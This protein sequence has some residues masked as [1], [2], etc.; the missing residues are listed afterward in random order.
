MPSF[1]KSLLITSFILIFTGLHW[2]GAV[3]QLTQVNINMKSAD[4]SAYMNYA[5]KM[6]Q[7]NYTFIGGRNRMPIYPFL[8]SLFYRPGMSNEAFFIRGKYV[9]LILSLVL[10]TGITFI[11]S[12]F[13][14]WLHTVN[15][16]L[17]TAFT[18]FVFKAGYFQAE[19]LFYFINFCLFLLM[20]RLLQQP[21]HLLAILTGFVAGLAHLT[22]ASIIP[23]L[24]LFLLFMGIQGAWTVYQN[25][26]SATRVT[27]TKSL[28]PHFLVI[29]L[30]G[31]CF[32]I[33]VYPYI[34]TSRRVFG[35]YFYNVNST[36]YVWY[37]SW[38][39]V[40]QGTR[41]HGDRVGW[42]NMPPEEIPSM[43]KYIREHTLQHI[44]ARFQYGKQLVLYNVMNNS[45]GYFK[46]VVIYFCL[47]IVAIVWHLTR[48]GQITVASP[49][50]CFFLPTY[51][52]AYFLLYTWYAVIAEG[53][54]LILA[55]FLPLMFVVS[56]GLHTVLRSS[57]VKIG[58]HPVNA[59]TA[60]N[61]IIFAII[62]VDIYFIIT[63]R[64]HTMFGG[65]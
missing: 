36:F 19:L 39:E 47:L 15:L 12:R 50:L 44:V 48:K 9:N 34:S 56:S 55:Q 52:V 46:Y 65:Q 42:P 25:R 3:Q 5:R 61:L 11:F 18:V 33:T 54:R 8:Q 4:Q 14:H 45:Y 27:F 21:S 59:L 16:V 38:K 40:K 35:H 32:L 28:T 37:D 62:I 7:S 6:Y 51:F 60:T 13:F 30:V 2:H 41:K 22:K 64:V 53:N 58:R 43:S 31:L 49:I 20:W 26:R 63:G 29:V 57:Q 17:I 10:L 1:V 24:V 23:G